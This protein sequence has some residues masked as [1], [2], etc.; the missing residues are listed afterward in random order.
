MEKAV[1]STKPQITNSQDRFYS[2]LVRNMATEEGIDMGEL[3][4]F[5]EAEKDG[6]VTKTDMLSYIK[7]RGTTSAEAAKPTQAAKPTPAPK[8]AESPRNTVLLLL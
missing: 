2:P 3:S 1:E 4:K 5:L 7:S 6:R 8:A